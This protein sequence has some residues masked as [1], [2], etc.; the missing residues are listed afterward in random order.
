MAS[1]KKE[2]DLRID[3]LRGIANNINGYISCNRNYSSMMDS[4]VTE[5]SIYRWFYCLIENY[6]LPIF[7]AIISGYVYAM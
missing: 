2:K 3:T 5:D 6:F 7:M 4:K 1:V